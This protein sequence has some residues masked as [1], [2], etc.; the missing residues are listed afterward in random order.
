MV[1]DCP[2]CL[3][4]GLL[5]EELVYEISER[6]GLEVGL[7]RDSLSFLNPKANTSLGPF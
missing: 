1:A 7:S 4:R 6:L 3:E 5:L 2:M